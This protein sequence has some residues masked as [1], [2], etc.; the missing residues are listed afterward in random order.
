MTRGV[1]IEMVVRNVYGE[2]PPNDRTITDNLV[3]TWLEPGIGLAAK[4]AYKDSI[5]FD[6]VSYVNNSFYT[7]FKGLP[8]VQEEDFVFKIELPQIP[9]GIGKNEGL[10]I[11][12][13]ADVNGKL[14]DPAIP[15]SENQ[16][17]FDNLPLTSANLRIFNPSFFP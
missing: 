2:Q 9:L 15:L 3:N 17:G 16:V 7:T 12:R 11:L 6:G 13:F 5:A 10:N 14:S 4:Q 8:I 1:F